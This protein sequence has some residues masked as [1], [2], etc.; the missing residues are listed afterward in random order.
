MEEEKPQIRENY[1]DEYFNFTCVL[2]GEVKYLEEIRE[3]IV[4]NYVLKGLIKLIKPTYSKDRIYILEESQWRE[5]NR[6]KE[7]EIR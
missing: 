3:H 2:R 1:F 5:Y 4:E 7:M 6:L